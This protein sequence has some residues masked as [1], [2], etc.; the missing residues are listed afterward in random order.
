MKQNFLFSLLLV[1]LSF[2]A[3]KE[4]TT[5]AVVKDIQS[6]NIVQSP[7]T[8]Y[9]TDE[10]S[11]VLTATATYTN[12]SVADVTENINWNS[13]DTS[14]LQMNKNTIS[15][16][17]KNGGDANISINYKEFSDSLAVHVVKLSDFNITNE[18]L[19]TTGQHTLEA[20]GYF[21]DTTNKVIYKNIVW[22]ANNSA[23]IT[24][25]NG[26]ATIELQNGVTEVNATVFKTDSDTNITKSVTYT[27]N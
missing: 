19:N 24:T 5:E 15:G 8:L 1:A 13:S 25:Q 2:T 22:E 20:T 4:T 21:E 18:D 9:S 10:N 16:V 23:V 26:I 12:G 14:L 11:I 6:I 17:Y 27:I 3:C 7:L